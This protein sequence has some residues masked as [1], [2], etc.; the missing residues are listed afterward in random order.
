MFG[1]AR[2]CDSGGSPRRAASGGARQD[3]VP[4]EAGLERVRA[5]PEHRRT[6]VLPRVPLPGK[7]RGTETANMAG[8][9]VL[10]I[11]LLGGV[12]GEGSHV[13]PL[14]NPSFFC[15]DYSDV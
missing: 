8:T 14:T 5:S 1:S 7:Q 6:R 10:L 3:L 11:M 12:K 2:F 13:P 9:L 15:R 4:R